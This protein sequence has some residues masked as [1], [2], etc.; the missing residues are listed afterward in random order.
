MH[1]AAIAE[2]LLKIV[3]EQAKV[4]EGRPIVGKVSYGH[5]YAINE[6]VL[7][8]AFKAIAEG[9]VCEGMKL[10]VEHKPLKAHCKMCG[11]DFVFD[12]TKCVCSGCGSEE[13]DMFADEPLILEEIEFETE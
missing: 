10:V 8:F 2:E 4:N 1:E 11:S 5:F 12:I 6:E 7:S 13:F 3:L 9:S